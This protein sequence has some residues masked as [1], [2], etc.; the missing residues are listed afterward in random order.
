M[1][2]PPVRQPRPQLGWTHTSAAVIDE[3]ACPSPSPCPRL[4]AAKLRRFG[5]AE[6]K[7]LTLNISHLS[8][9]YVRSEL[10]PMINGTT[11]ERGDSRA[12]SSLPSFPRTETP[13][14]GEAGSTHRHHWGGPV[15]QQLAR[16]NPRRPSQHPH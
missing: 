11:F 7:P 9:F 16:R 15:G 10:R 6:K 13:R 1:P 8:H 14:Y 2:G 4:P 5:K 12:P 3:I